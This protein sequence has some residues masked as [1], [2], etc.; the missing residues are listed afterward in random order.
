[1][2]APWFNIVEIVEPRLGRSMADIVRDVSEAYNISLAELRRPSQRR[3]YSAAR[4]AA[5]DAVHRERPDLS[6]SMV[7]RFLNRD[8]SSVRHRW[9]Q[10][11]RGR[12]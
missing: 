9:L 7:G 5:Y 4:N 10:T 8:G 11:S 1:M 2:K 12:P 6:S 3:M